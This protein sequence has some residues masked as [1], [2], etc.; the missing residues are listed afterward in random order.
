MPARPLASTIRFGAVLAA[1]ALSACT[2][3]PDFQSPR[4]ATPAQYLS[5]APPS[6]APYVS[7]DP[8][9]PLW[10]NSFGDNTLTQLESQAVAQNLDLQIA[11]ERL[12]EAEAQAQITGAALYPSL[13][14]A[15]SYTREGPSKEGIFNAFGTGGSAGAANDAGGIANGSGASI[16]GGGFSSSAIQPLDLYQYGLQSMYDLDL[17]G[18][19][20]RAAEA[21]VAAARASEEA[22]RASLLNVEAQVA[23]NYIQLRGVETIIDITQ[24]NL[25]FANQLVDLTVERQQAGLTTALDVANAR[26]IAAQIAS[27]IPG[28]ITQRDAFI[29]QIGLLLGVTPESLP[30]ELVTIGPVPLTPPQVP[31]GLP[32]DLL[33]RRPDVRE[34]EQSLH[35][36]T[37]EIG[38]AVAQFF[39]DL[40]LSG[41]VSLQAL[42]LK[43]LNEFR[44]IT[45]AVGPELSLPIFEGGQL[46]GQLKL[47]RAQQREAAIAYARTVLTAF[48]QVDNALV[49]YTQAHA[50]L[51][52]LTIDVQQSQI[53]LGLAEDQYRGGLA[54]YLT[55]LNAQQS[56]LNAQQTQAQALAGLSNDLVTVYQALGGGWSQAFP[57]SSQ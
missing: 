5:D 32:A 48:Y 41:S 54:D 50:T 46:R 22:R 43:N 18:K 16:G 55:V 52:D 47:R 23:S 7:G 8:V 53:A 49:T 30:V 26:A 57:E 39:P 38:V 45:Y 10:W 44:A 3:G 25:T 20:R 40:S 14:G 28:L 42:Q 29:D 36:A 4:A 24:R 56:Y 17:W 2:V 34:A 6:D 13:A 31:I 1:M 15:A 27:Q 11:T 12:V 35:E 19:N 33:R 51:A 21:A 9:D 37:A